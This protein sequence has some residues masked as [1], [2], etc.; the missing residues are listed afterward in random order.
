G[1]HR[2]ASIP[3]APH[4]PPE[5]RGPCGSPRPG[6]RRAHRRLARTGRAGR[7][8]GGPRQDLFARHA[9]AP[10]RGAL[11]ALR[12]RAADPRR[13]DERARSRGHPRV[14]A[15]HPGDRDRAPAPAARPRHRRGARGSRGR[16]AGG[17]FPDHYHPA[18]GPSLMF[19]LRLISADLLKLRRRRGM[20]AIAIALT[21]GTVL[22]GFGVMAIQHGSNP[23]KHG[24]AGGL[25]NFQ[26][27]IGF[28][29]LMAIVAGVIVG[30]T[31]GAQD[32]ESGV[33]RDLVA[34]GRSR[35]ALFGA[36]APAAWVIL[37]PICAATAAIA[38]LASVALACA[39]PTPGGVALIAGTIAVVTA[40][41][42]SAVVAVGLSAL[43]G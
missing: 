20:L 38:G 33:F 1:D 15:P 36:R 31:A 8:V 43:V 9:P 39:L 6:R 12:P 26:D 22:L 40:G 4:R 32:L 37:V 27:A 10:R 29:T 28:E 42:L 24:P 2:R 19:D 14:P 7:A 25:V 5:P 35:M 17:P 34:T 41:A 30:T 16:L 23:I 3:R 11:P 13:A 18:G 21:I